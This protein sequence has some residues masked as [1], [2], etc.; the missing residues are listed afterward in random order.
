MDVKD[1]II[2]VTGAASGIG[3]ALVVRLKPKGRN[4]LSRLISILSVLKRRQRW[5]VA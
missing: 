1:K 5:L 3:R 2:V 4:R